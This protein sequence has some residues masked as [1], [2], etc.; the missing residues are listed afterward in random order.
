MHKPIADAI[1]KPEHERDADERRFDDL[2][3][4]AAEDARLRPLFD[5]YYDLVHATKRESDVGIPAAESDAFAR[6]LD[7]QRYLL[8]TYA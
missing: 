3:D 7:L 6:M 1:A 8:D 2:R 4:R 5:L